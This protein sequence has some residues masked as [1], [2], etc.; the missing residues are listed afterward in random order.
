MSVVWIAIVVI[1]AL[2]LLALSVRVVKRYERHEAGHG[3]PS[4]DPT[5]DGGLG[6]YAAGSP[7]TDALAMAVA[8]A[9]LA[10]SIHHPPPWRWRMTGDGLDLRL[11]SNRPLDVNDPDARLA[12]LSCGAALH[13][14]RVSLGARG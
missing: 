4:R 8:A 6:R 2:L 12:T 1:L 9:S 10:P 14:A 13:H 3:P 11:D 5:G 7:V